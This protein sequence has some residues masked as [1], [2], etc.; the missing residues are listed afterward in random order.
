VSDVFFILEDFEQWS[1]EPGFTILGTVEYDGVRQPASFVRE[2]GGFRSFYTMP[3]FQ[4]ESFLDP[5]VKRHI[6]AGIMWAVRR[7]QLLE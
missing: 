5:L 4:P 2:W 1:G 7:E 3:G 6:A